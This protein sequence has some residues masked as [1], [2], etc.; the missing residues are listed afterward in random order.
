MIKSNKGDVVIKGK[1]VQVVAEGTHMV[2]ELLRYIF[3]I[4]DKKVQDC[5]L[6]DFG[7]SILNLLKAESLEDLD[8]KLEDVFS[9]EDEENEDMICKECA[10]K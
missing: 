7:L 1:P 5:L 3:S 9:E 2:Y 6:Y 10:N 8:K 4:E